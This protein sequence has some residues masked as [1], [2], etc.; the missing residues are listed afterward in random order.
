MQQSD[1]KQHVIA[2]VGLVASAFVLSA[3]FLVLMPKP[4]TAKPTA[5][6]TIEEKVEV[7]V[8]RDKSLRN[9]GRYAISKDVCLTGLPA[10]DELISLELQSIENQFMTAINNPDVMHLSIQF[11]LN[12][13]TEEFALGRDRSLQSVLMTVTMNSGGAH[14]GTTLRSWTFDRDTGT[15]YEL[16]DLFQTEH[17]PLLALEPL[18]QADLLRSVHAEPDKIRQGTD[19]DQQDNYRTFYLDGDSLV[20][21]FK[22][23]QVAAQAAGVKRVA[24]PIDLLQAVLR[25]P[26]LD[27]VAIYGDG[28]APAEPSLEEMGLDCEEAGGTWSMTFAECEYV[29]REWCENVMGRFEECASACRHD[30]TAEICTMQCVPVCYL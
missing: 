14:P 5:V 3:A 12:A 20:V 24:I 2:I 26:F 29:G 23:G 11:S 13:S 19:S 10:V 6:Q 30:P 4:E 17:N 8:G 1:T 18:V 22:P 16:M 27:T 25:P 15:V 9:L 21:A 28:N 7:C